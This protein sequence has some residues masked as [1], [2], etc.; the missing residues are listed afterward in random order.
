MYGHKQCIYVVL[1]NFCYLATCY[2]LFSL[3]LIFV[4]TPSSSLCEKW[5]KLGHLQGA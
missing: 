5:P 3:R 1:A 2:L 4:L